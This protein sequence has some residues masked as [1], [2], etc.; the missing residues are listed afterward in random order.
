MRSK[1]MRTTEMI[2]RCPWCGKHL[3]RSSSVNCEEAPEE[4]DFTL[5]F[6]CGEWSVFASGMHLRKPDDEEFDEIGT[7]PEM[8]K[9]RWA[10]TEAKN[11]QRRDE[12]AKRNAH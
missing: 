4:G 1:S 6:G 7:D 8:M 11:Q 5:C 10:W 12:E 2:M 3:D 9:V